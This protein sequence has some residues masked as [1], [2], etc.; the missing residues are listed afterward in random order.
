[1][2]LAATVMGAD[3]DKPKK[4]AWIILNAT[5]GV[6][7]LAEATS[8]M[9][10]VRLWNAAKKASKEVATDAYERGKRS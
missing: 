2:G 10:A 4:T 8:R 5:G 9:N 6:I 1:M 3:M 7:G